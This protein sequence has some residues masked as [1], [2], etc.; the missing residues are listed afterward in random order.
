MVKFYKYNI[1]KFEEVDKFGYYI[2]ETDEGVT[3]HF[4]PRAYKDYKGLRELVND[5]NK[6]N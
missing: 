4:S 5:N 1:I 3:L 2:F 6:E